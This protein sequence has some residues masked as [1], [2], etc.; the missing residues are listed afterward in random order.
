MAAQASITLNTVVY[1]PTG[2]L[3]Q[4]AGWINRA[5][6]VPN[7]FS[8]A[9]I[10]VQSPSPGGSVYRVTA[11]L[12]LP[13]VAA[14]D[15]SCVCAGDVLRDGNVTVQ[16]LLPIT[17]TTAERTDLYLRLKDLIASAPFIDAVENLVSTTS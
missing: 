11:R 12:S 15:T 4:D 13:V 3:N 17:G 1:V 8:D 10:K 16:F 9:D 6:G 5:G 7:S 14:T 2:V